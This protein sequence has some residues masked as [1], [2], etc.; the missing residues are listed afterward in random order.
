M[1]PY[2]KIPKSRGNITLVVVLMLIT[3]GLVTTCVRDNN[4]PLTCVQSSKVKEIISVN[5]RSADIKLTSGEVITLNQ[6][7]IK[8][9]DDYCLKYMRKDELK[10]K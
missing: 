4:N 10:T 2:Y 8:P 9:G 6:A 3:A 1:R 7:T 5:Y